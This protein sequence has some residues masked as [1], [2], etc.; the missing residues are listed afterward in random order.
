MGAEIPWLAL[1]GTCSTKTFET[2]YHTLGMGG[3]RPFYGIDRGADR[4]NL[5]QWVRPMEY[6]AS[7]LYDLLAFIPKSPK[8]PSDLPKTIFYLK[9]RQLSRRACDISR[10]ALPPELRK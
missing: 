2:I 9:T 4:P 6:P 7:S 8:G 10:A 1:T 5:A 3:T